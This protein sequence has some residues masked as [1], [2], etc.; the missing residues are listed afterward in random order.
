MNEMMLR[1]IED[2][3]R[4]LAEALTDLRRQASGLPLPEAGD[5][6]LTGSGDS[7]FAAMAVEMLFS[8]ES[9]RAVWALPSLSL[10]R[11]PRPAGSR[12]VVA[13]SVSGEV[14]RTLEAASAEAER[15]STVIAI[16]ANAD[17]SLAR[18]ADGYLV[19]PTPLSRQTPHTRDYTL[20]LL[21]LAVLC[22]HLAGHRLE[23]LDLWPSLA[24][25]TIPAALDWAKT[26]LP[27]PPERTVWFAGAG[28]DR[29]TAAFGALKLWETGASL[30]GW[31]D[32]EEFAHGP[33]L[34]A[35]AGDDVVLLAAERAATRAYELVP[36]LVKL[37]LRPILIGPTVGAQAPPCP[38]FSPPALGDWAWSPF[39][40]CLP[41]EALSY[42]YAVHREIDIMLPLGG[43]PHGRIY[44]EV[45]DEWMRDS[46]METASDD[47]SEDGSR[48]R[49]AG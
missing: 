12:L 46:A 37:G 21:A 43:K 6:V 48:D 2:Q 38:H 11:F 27:A 44:N 29:G 9:G 25:A 33:S 28:P 39:L 16:V 1:E 31:D 47:L 19:M 49:P 40:S 7:L 18:M 24:R 4:A 34:I 15:G 23:A 5:V 22:E 32:L 26:L 8:R 3:P 45:Y 36:G 42:V 13:I 35:A 20:T 10:S 41:V 14:I 17:S 30:A